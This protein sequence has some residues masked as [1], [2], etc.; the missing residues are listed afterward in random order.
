MGPRFF[1]LDAHRIVKKCVADFACA[2]PRG[3]L[4]LSAFW[5]IIEACDGEDGVGALFAQEI[6]N[7]RRRLCARVWEGH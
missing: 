3:A 4:P 5:D 2:S 7:F 6:D 1:H